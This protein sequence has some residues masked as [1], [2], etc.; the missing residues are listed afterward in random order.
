MKHSST[1]YVGSDIREKIQIILNIGIQQIRYPPI[2]L[3]IFLRNGGS[4]I[5]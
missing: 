2:V 5:L 4:T 3:I 1:L